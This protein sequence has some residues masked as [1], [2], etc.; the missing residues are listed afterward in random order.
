MDS[1]A[2]DRRL[3]LIPKHAISHFISALRRVL[4]FPAT[5]K[6]PS[7][8]VYNQSL[9][10]NFTGGRMQFINDVHGM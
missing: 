8:S 5:A 10:Y 6:R 2:T 7:L 3:V 4:N 1:I 9:Q